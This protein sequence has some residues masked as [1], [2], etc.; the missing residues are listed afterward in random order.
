MGDGLLAVSLSAAVPLIIMSM[1]QDKG[2]PNEA[3]FHKARCYG[4]VLANKGDNLLFK[5]KKKGET[6]E[7]FNGLAHAV[8]TMA[9]MPGG[10]KIFGQHYIGRKRRRDL[11]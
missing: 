1:E 10:I 9:F 3:D 11:L 8:A 2:R 7:L 5:S 6:A 4:N